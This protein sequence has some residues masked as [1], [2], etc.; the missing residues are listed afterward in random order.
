MSI[1]KPEARPHGRVMSAPA[2]ADS[3][4]PFERK[5]PMMAAEYLAR[6]SGG[7]LCPCCGGNEVRSGE[8]Q[9]VYACRTCQRAWVELFWPADYGNAELAG[10]L[11]GWDRLGLRA[12]VTPEVSSE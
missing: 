9:H 3:S 4:E 5:L 10:Q 2:P 7:R 6:A 8:G 1:N 11:R 12:A